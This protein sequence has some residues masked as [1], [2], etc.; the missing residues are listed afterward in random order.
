MATGVRISATAA[1]TGAAGMVIAT[2]GAM[3]AV[4]GAKVAAVGAMI[5]AEDTTT[6]LIE[7]GVVVVVVE[8]TEWVKFANDLQ[9]RDNVEGTTTEE[10][11]VETADVKEVVEDATKL[12]KLVVTV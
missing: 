10:S 9:S 1:M 11:G 2:V 8:L 12:V 7:G 5:A 3:I 6:V 4:V